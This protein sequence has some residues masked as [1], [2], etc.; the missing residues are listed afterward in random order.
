[1][2]IESKIELVKKG[3]VSEILTDSDLRHVFETQAH[4][5]HYIGFEISG[6][7][8]IATGLLTTLKIRDLIKAGVKPTIFLADYHAWING[9]MGGDLQVIQKIAKGYFK[10]C[11]YSLGLEDGQVEFVMG[12]ELYEKIGKDYW[13]DVLKITN[14]TTKERMLRCTTIMGR[15]E[16]DSALPSSAMI[17]PAMQVAD[18]WAMD[19]DI[20]HAGMDQRKIHVLARELSDK[21]KKPKPVAIHMKLLPGLKSSKRMDAVS[22]SEEDAQ[23]DNKMSKSDPNS[24]IFIHDS[25]DEIVRKIK[26]ANCPEKIVEDNPMIEY[27]NA[28]ILRD[29]PLEIKR[30]QKFGGDVQYA[31]LDELKKDFSCAKLHPVDLKNAVGDEL[32]K[33][34]EPSRG[35]FENKQDLIEMVKKA[36]E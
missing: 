36:R 18:M 16:S 21:M 17:Y 12:S 35:Y 33:M 20:A 15:K 29:R 11:F 28:F 10:E 19:I 34:L 7:V 6:L 31:T 4:P 1:M 23:I 22:V 26:K 25:Q 5:R 2:D 30:P 13:S 27:A 8:H 3:T 24:A 14:N 9:K 32:A